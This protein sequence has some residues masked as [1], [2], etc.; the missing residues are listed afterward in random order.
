MKPPARYHFALLLTR[1]PLAAVTPPH[2]HRANMYTLSCS[3]RA[4]PRWNPD[5]HAL[6]GHSLRIAVRGDTGTRRRGDPG[7]RI[8]CVFVRWTLVRRKMCQP[9]PKMR[10]EQANAL[11]INGL[12]GFTPRESARA[13]EVFKE[14]AGS[15]CRT[16]M[17]SAWRLNSGRGCWGHPKQQ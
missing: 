11:Q 10:F 9:N 17:A 1:F 4:N 14:P 6:P 16:P 8:L 7:W 13:D 12:Y 15:A 2:G 3:R 5:S